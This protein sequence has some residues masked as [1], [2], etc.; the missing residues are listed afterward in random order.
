MLTL[1]LYSGNVQR[2]EVL[3]KYTKITAYVFMFFYL[4]VAFSHINGLSESNF[5]QIINNQLLSNNELSFVELLSALA[6][7]AAIMVFVA[8]CIK[9]KVFV[10]R[11]IKSFWLIVFTLVAIL[12]FG[13]EI[14]WGD[15]FFDYSVENELSQFNAQG[16]TNLH[17]INL[18]ELL[19]LDVKED[20]GV[21]RYLHNAGH[22]L[23]PIFYLLLAILWVGLPLVANFFSKIKLIANIPQPSREFIYLFLVH[24]VIFILVDTLLINVGQLFEMFIG[25]CAL[26]VALDL[27]YS[28]ESF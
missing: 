4:L 23:T 27:Y 2:G 1:A 13:E 6:W 15:H 21:Y 18:I 17:N 14:S 5:A 22:A 11:G 12:A 20:S 3:S 10:N 26:I 25:F 24:S 28:T 19:D 8:V 16:E 9:C 7:S